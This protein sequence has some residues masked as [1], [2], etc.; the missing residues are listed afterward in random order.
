MTLLTAS[1]RHMVLDYQPSQAN[2]WPA[3]F[4]QQVGVTIGGHV[5][6]TDFTYQN[7]A[8]TVSLVPFGQAG[9][10]PDPVY[11]AVP[12]DPG[13]K[14]QQTLDSAFSDYYTFRY[15]GDSP[16]WGQLAVQSYSTFTAEPTQSSPL[17][18]FGADLYI[19]YI[20]GDRRPSPALRGNLR[21]IQVV[22]NGQP[23]FVDCSRRAN[24]FFNAAGLTSV[25]GHQVVSFA[26]TPQG[27]ANPG[28]ALT[29]PSLWT[30]ETFLAEDTGITD[31]SGKGI[32]TLFGGLK[33]GWQIQKQ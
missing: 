10:S 23:L 25:Y 32:V 2:G 29:L 5:A 1:S 13:I 17:L 27:G 8:Y 33:Y 7:T 31:R 22:S 16:G 11:E 21:W 19:V 12:A 24:P 4:G 18:R 15:A 20:P 3:E 30:A 9:D 6:S 14:F 28:T 26:D